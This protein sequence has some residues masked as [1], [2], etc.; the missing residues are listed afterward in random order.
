[1]SKAANVSPNIA[2]AGVQFLTYYCINISGAVVHRLQPHYSK[3]VK[4]YM[5]TSL[6]GL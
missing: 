5:K 3:A 2:R 6:A 4:Y 1:M